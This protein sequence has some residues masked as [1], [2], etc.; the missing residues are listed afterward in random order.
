M[1]R[2]VYLLTKSLGAE[3]V[4]FVDGTEA[5]SGQSLFGQP[6]LTPAQLQPYRYARV[7]VLVA[8]TW[9][10]EIG[11]DLINRGLQHGKH[12]VV[13]QR[14]LSNVQ[15]KADLKDPDPVFIGRKTYGYEGLLAYYPSARPRHIGAFGSFA[16]GTRLGINH[17]YNAV[18]SHPFITH[19]AH[20]II[21]EDRLDLYAPYNPPIVIGNDVWLGYNSCILPGVTIGNGAI[22]GSGAVVTKDIPP[23]AIAVGS[24]ARVI[25]F[26]FDEKQISLLEKVQWWTWSDRRLRK[27]VE[28]LRDPKRF[29]SL[30]ERLVDGQGP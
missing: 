3:V 30:A 6:V 17:C 13:V 7:L 2:Q 29:F 10:R 25:R 9:W 16:V 11:V 22:V 19:R 8:S 21:P 15:W 23:Y 14:Q 4:A 27:H 20:G 5:T 18:T 12:F 1:A 24:P 26:R 28:D